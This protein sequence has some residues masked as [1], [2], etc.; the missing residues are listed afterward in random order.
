MKKISRRSFLKTGATA[1]AA[2]IAVPTI[3]STGWYA[4]AQPEA[5][6]AS[7]FEL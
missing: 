4:Q 6:W 3:L 7:V 5:P 2:T 1:A